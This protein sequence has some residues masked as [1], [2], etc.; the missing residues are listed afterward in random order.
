MKEVNKIREIVDDE[1]WVAKLDKP[2][3]SFEQYL[4]YIGD[5]CYQ[6]T[7]I[8]KA[9]PLEIDEI[10]QIKRTGELGGFT[11]LKLVYVQNV[12]RIEE[13]TFS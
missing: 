12:F 3:Y 13:K 8:S 11:G 7:G 9:T 6:L 1:Y 10:N 2:G 5:G 4:Y